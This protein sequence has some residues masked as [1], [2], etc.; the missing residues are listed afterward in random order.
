MKVTLT[1]N[2]DNAMKALKELEESLESIY[3][4][5]KEISSAGEVTVV[6]SSDQKPL[7]VDVVVNRIAY[8]INGEVQSII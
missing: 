8:S 1:I 4:K 5:T 6:L 3:K 2:A 7:D